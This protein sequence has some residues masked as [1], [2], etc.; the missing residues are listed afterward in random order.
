M[1]SCP[2]CQRSDEN[3][4]WQ[5]Q[6]CRVIRV[7]DPAYPAFLRVIWHQHV[8]EMSDLALADRRHLMNVVLAAEEALRSLV[9]PVKINLASFGNQVPHLHWHVIPRHPQDRHFPEPVWGTPQRPGQALAAPDD[10]ILHDAIRDTLAEL[11]SG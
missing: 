5:D 6:A 11:T 2:L 7:E 10:T 3:L 1:S 8:Q 4:I 9:N